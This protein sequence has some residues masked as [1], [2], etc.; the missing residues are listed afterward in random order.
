MDEKEGKRIVG[1]HHLGAEKSGATRLSQARPEARLWLRDHLGRQAWNADNPDGPADRAGD[2]LSG[3]TG[4]RTKEGEPGRCVATSSDF[5]LHL[6]SVPRTN[7]MNV[8]AI[9]AYLGDCRSATAMPLT[10]IIPNDRSYSRFSTTDR[11]LSRS[12][13]KS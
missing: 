6:P 8:P 13:T 12:N 7:P 10:D 4:R 11:E 9:V 5:E 1:V 2:T 3:K